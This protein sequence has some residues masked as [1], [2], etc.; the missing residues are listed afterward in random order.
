MWRSH[1]TT[2]L[3]AF[4]RAIREREAVC[5]LSTDVTCWHRR[6]CIVVIII[7]VVIALHTPQVWVRC[8]L[9]H[10]LSAEPL[11][12]YRGRLKMAFGEP[13]PPRRLFI[14]LT[15]RLSPRTHGPETDRLNRRRSTY[16]LKN[17]TGARRFTDARA[18]PR[19][20][21]GAYRCSRP[22]RTHEVAP[23]SMQMVSYQ[24]ISSK[25]P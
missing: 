12:F 25:V 18:R 7:V 14:F 8:E 21:P 20:N 16:E 15:S 6:N 24:G 17:R 13:C 5:V 10:T 22:T 1:C 4:P 23:Y 2:C 3:L 19:T 9:F 11:R